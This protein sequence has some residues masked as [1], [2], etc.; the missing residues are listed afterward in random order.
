M[1]KIKYEKIIHRNS[2]KIFPRVN[3]PTISI[4]LKWNAIFSGKLTQ[5]VIYFYQSIRF[6]NLYVLYFKLGIIL[7]L[8]K[9]FVTNIV[10]F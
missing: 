7:L 2:F 10:C 1:E 9:L 6:I 5:S 3:M 8:N 4:I